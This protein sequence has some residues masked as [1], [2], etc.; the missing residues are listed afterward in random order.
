MS[1]NV[2]LTP[3]DR[4]T[5]RPQTQSVAHYL[6]LAFATTSPCGRTPG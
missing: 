4:C 6:H 3:L 2:L 1:V 5:R